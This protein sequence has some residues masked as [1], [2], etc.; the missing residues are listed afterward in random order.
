MMVRPR[1]AHRLPCPSLFRAPRGS[2]LARLLCPSHVLPL[3]RLVHVSCPSPPSPFE[4]LTLDGHLAS[5]VRAGRGPPEVR[6]PVLARDWHSRSRRGIAAAGPN[7]RRGQTGGEAAPAAVGAAANMTDTSKSG[8]LNEAAALRR[9]HALKDLEGQRVKAKI[10]LEDLCIHPQNRGGTYP[11]AARAAGLV[12]GI[13]KDR[14]LKE[15]AQHA[16]AAAVI[17]VE[18][19]HCSGWTFRSTSARLLRGRKN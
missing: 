6:P 12:C 14:F 19:L 7:C 3:R 18:E 11:S 8:P 1:G 2:G 5:Q 10:S 16:A 4:L 13:L 9:R 17:A 15:E